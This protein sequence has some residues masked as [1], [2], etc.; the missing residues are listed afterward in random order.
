MLGAVA[1]EVSNNNEKNPYS[2]AGWRCRI[3]KIWE[4]AYCTITLLRAWSSGS[5]WKSLERCQSHGRR[6]ED[7]KRHIDYSSR[8][9]CRLWRNVISYVACEH[10]C[11]HLI[12]TWKEMNL[13]DVNPFQF[14]IKFNWA[15]LLRLAV[16][17][18][19]EEWEECLQDRTQLVNQQKTHCNPGAHIPH[20]MEN[21][22]SWWHLSLCW[23]GR[24]RNA[25]NGRSN[26]W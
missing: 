3:F 2:C 13:A 25:S 9:H 10:P 14:Q 6:H 20:K 19:W 4:Y 7:K 1:M 18:W 11:N 23:T 5:T 26:R 22:G 12:W 24:R 17:N 15:R 21:L 8:L 16:L